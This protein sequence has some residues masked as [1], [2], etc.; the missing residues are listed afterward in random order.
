AAVKLV[1]LL[2]GHRLATDKASALTTLH[3]RWYPDETPDV[4]IG[5]GCEGGRLS[6]LDCL[7]RTGTWTKLRQLDLPVV[8]QL[9][10]PDGV[11]HYATL[12][13]LDKD[14]ATLELGG[15]SFSFALAEIDPFWD[16]AYILLWKAPP[17]SATLLGPGTRGKDVEWLSQ[18]LRAIDGQRLDGPRRDVY[19]DELKA[20]VMAFQRSHSLLADGIVGEETLFQLAAAVPP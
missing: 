17:V 16:G 9:S 13:G 5:P 1:D 19:D 14:R 15:R 10:G 8:I 18:R 3:A 12:I 4:A 20:R 2:S 7:A 6:G 11:R